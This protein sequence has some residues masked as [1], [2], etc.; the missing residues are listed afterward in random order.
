MPYFTIFN[1]KPTV[2]LMNVCENVTVDPMLKF[3]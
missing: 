3:G 2:E 1:R